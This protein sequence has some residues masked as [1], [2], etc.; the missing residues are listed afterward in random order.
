[1]FH[2]D[3]FY[4]FVSTFTRV[5]RGIHEDVCGSKGSQP[6]ITEHHL[7]VASYADLKTLFGLEGGILITFEIS[8][9]IL[10]CKNCFDHFKISCSGDTDSLWGL[11]SS[12][13]TSRR[14]F[15]LLQQQDFGFLPPSYYFCLVIVC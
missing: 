8:L 13:F 14:M 15:P 1:M 10:E 5:W 11:I 7:P 6:Y 12:C 4:A 2:L 9:R 3:A